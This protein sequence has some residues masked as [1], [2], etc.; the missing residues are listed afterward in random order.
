MSVCVKVTG[1]LGQGFDLSSSMQD[2]YVFHDF[3]DE[4]MQ[5]DGP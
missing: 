3:K 5:S 4:T 2:S 1:I